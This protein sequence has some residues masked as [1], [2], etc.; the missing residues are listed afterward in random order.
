MRN[1]ALKD[2]LWAIDVNPV[3]CSL[4]VATDLLRTNSETQN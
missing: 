2:P 4:H 1:V 3:V